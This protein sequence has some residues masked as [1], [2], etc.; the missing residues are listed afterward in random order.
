MYKEIYNSIGAFISGIAVGFLLCTALLSNDKI[1][2][3]CQ[4]S[5]PRDQFCKLIAVPAT[6]P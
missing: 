3:E 2:R 5:L 4:K 6:Q 1:L